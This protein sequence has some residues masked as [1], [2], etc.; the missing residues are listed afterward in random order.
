MEDTSNKATLR[1]QEIPDTFISL[2]EH[3][4]TGFSSKEFILEK[5]RAACTPRSLGS[6]LRRLLPVLEWL[7]QYSPRTQLLGDVIS[8]LLVGIVAI[9]QSISYSLLANQ[10]P[11][12]GI[13]T[14]FFCNIIY[15]AAATSR[16]ASVG[17][18]G[19]LC[20]MVGQS[21]TRH[22]QL[23]GYGDSSAGLGDNSSSP[24]N[25]TEGCDR[26]CY[27]ITVALS[28]SFLVGLYQVQMVTL[29]LFPAGN[30]SEFV[31]S[32]CWFRL[33][34]PEKCFWTLTPL[35]V[36]ECSDFKSA[37]TAGW[38]L[39]SPVGEPGPGMCLKH[40]QDETQQERRRIWES[41]SQHLNLGSLEQFG[42]GRTTLQCPHWAIPGFCTGTTK[43]QSI[44]TERYPE[45]L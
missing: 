20:L 35:S 33:K 3:E 1:P 25:G 37:N 45:L 11:I 6:S 9:P 27:A 15:A 24:S 8:G 4:P 7:P 41:P 19:V 29:V 10:D 32:K 31:M 39:V 30:F 12:Y 43:T 26:S 22:L 13:Y 14:N 16:H 38:G 21:V 23:A 36:C 5:A 18:F 28:L 17:S 40:P 2:E 42:A 44:T 34:S